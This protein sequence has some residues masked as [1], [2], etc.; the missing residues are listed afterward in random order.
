VVHYY[1]PG[2][3]V[4][5][6]IIT[7]PVDTGFDSFY[8]RGSQERLAALEELVREV[9]DKNVCQEGNSDGN[10]PLLGYILTQ[11]SMKNTH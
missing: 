3:W 7:I 6:G 4:W 11:R 8:F 10:N 2:Y 1:A 5:L 9:D